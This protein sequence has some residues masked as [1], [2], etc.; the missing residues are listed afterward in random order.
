VLQKKIQELLKRGLMMRVGMVLAVAALVLFALF[1]LRHLHVT[2]LERRW[3]RIE[4]QVTRLESLQEQISTYRAWYE[5]EARSLM[6]VMALTGAFPESG[7]A[8]VRSVEI[9]DQARVSCDGFARSD[10]DWLRLL[11]ALGELEGI[12]DLQVKQVR[13]QN[14][15]QFS[16]SFQWR[17]G[18]HHGA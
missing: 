11:D 15:V 6:M 1:V 2:V 9:E 4:P 10:S 7:G 17:G 13:G 5:D 3:E 14:P 18:A 8:W 12:E 16:F